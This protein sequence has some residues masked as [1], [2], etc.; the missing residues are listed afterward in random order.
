MGG[1]FGFGIVIAADGMHAVS[2]SVTCNGDVFGTR[3]NCS[4]DLSSQSYHLR[5]ELGT[6]LKSKRLRAQ[7]IRAAMTA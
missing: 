2:N 3:L 5:P 7:D 1:D 6:V 4:Y